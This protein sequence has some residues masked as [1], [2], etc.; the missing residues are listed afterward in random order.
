LNTQVLGISTDPIPTLQAWAASFGGI[1]YPLLSDFWPH[2]AVAMRYGVLRPEGYTERALFLIDREGVLR[3]CRVYPI[4]E[5]PNNEEWLDIIR[6]MDPHAARAENRPALP[7]LPRGGIVIY[8]TPWCTDCR[9]LRA[10]LGAHNLAYTEV[11]IHTTD[12]AEARVREWCG[13]RLITPTIDIDGEIIIDFDRERLQT[14]LG[15]EE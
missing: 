15:I 11:D 1:E 9:A 14:L 10:W 5:Q 6:E 3:N 4:D 8:C 12:G 2:G 13:G 7:V